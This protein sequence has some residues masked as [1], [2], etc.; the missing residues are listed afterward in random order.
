MM[1]KEIELTQGK[2]ALVDDEDYEELIKY[3][4]YAHYD[5]Y[6][7]Y[8]VTNSPSVN[9]KRHRII[10][11]RK[12]LGLNIRDGKMVDHRD[13]VTLNNRRSNLRVVSQSVNNQNHSGYSHNTS[14]HNGVGW[15]KH[16]R[17]WRAYIKVNNKSIHL[18]QHTNINAAIEAR[19]QGEL[20]YWHDPR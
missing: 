19:K 12:I 16:S 5:G 7:Y 11:H 9:G 18:G 13:C 3:K 2:I 8:A 14:G 15:D 10:M 6:N 20:D 1:T 4:W 17:K